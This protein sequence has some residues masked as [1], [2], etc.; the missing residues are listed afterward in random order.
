MTAMP[1]I[2]AA[3]RIAACSFVLSLLA[4]GS[5]SALP[6]WLLP[7][8]WTAFPTGVAPAS[9][10]TVVAPGAKLGVRPGPGGGVGLLFNGPNHLA[11]LVT[12]DAARLPLRLTPAGAA[13]SSTSGGQI[14]FAPLSIVEQLRLRHGRFEP[15]V[16][17][18]ITVPFLLSTQLS[19]ALRQAG[20]DAIRRPDHPALVVNTGFDFALSERTALIVDLHWVPFAETLVVV[21][22]GEVFKSQELMLDVNPLTLAVG[23][24]W[25]PFRP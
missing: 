25:R 2:R 16:G 3:T 4:A 7:A 13:G 10:E 19:N 8:E 20:V 9:A 14:D 12:L 17:A 15:Y 24:A 11:T 22:R 23:V 1:A 5:S 21:P 18:G 6:S